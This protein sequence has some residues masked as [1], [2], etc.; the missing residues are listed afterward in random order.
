MKNILLL[1]PNERTR[2]NI[3]NIVESLKNTSYVLANEFNDAVDAVVKQSFDLIVVDADNLVMSVL[4]FLLVLNGLHRNISVIVLDDDNASAKSALFAFR[5][6]IIDYL[7]RPLDMQYLW[8]TLSQNLNI[9]FSAPSLEE[10]ILST[11]VNTDTDDYLRPALLQ[12]STQQFRALSTSLSELQSNLNADLVLLND[13]HENIIAAAGDLQ[14]Y[15]LLKLRDNLSLRT[16]INS[17][18]LTV[19]DKENFHASYLEGERVSIYTIT[20]QIAPVFSLITV[21]DKAVKVG[22]IWTHCRQILHQLDNILTLEPSHI[23]IMG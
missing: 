10:A 23:P 3:I 14:H 17:T 20:S 16:Q 12:L 21:C 1:L 2:E 4:D 8:L 15:G 7:T 11:S 9:D 22:A 19:F 13:E 18:M 5:M 6:G